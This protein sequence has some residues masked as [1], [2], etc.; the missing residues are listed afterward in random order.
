MGS[1]MNVPY[2]CGIFLS[3]SP[4]L[5][6]SVLGPGSVVPTYLSTNTT[7]TTGQSLIDEY[8]SIPSPLFSNIENSRR[9]RALPVYA[10]LIS[11]GRDGLAE[12]I[13]RNISFARTVETWMRFSPFYD[14]LTPP[15]TPAPTPSSYKVLNIVLFAPSSLAPTRFQGPGGAALLC[16][17]INASKECYVTGTTWRGRGGIRLAVSNWD[18]R[19]ERDWEIVRR[20]LERAME[21]E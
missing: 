14:I 8:R 20:V 2:D 1:R 10:S 5:L 15:P 13:V 11:L 19:V 12:M 6:R 18:T 3:T 7:D 17:S 9:F 16:Q 4:S 21:E